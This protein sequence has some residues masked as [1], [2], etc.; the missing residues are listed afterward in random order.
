MTTKDNFSAKLIKKSDTTITRPLYVKS[1][2]STAKTVTVKFPGAESGVYLIALESTDIGRIEETSLE[3]TVEGRVTG[4]V[5]LTG[6]YLGGTLVTITGVNFSNDPLDNP[7]KAGNSWCYVQ[8]TSP[9][10]ITCRVAETGLTAASS[11]PLSTFLRTSEEAVVDI[12]KTFTFATPSATVSS[13]TASFVDSS[14]KQELTLVG[15]GF[16]TDHT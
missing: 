15:I 7:V 14:L 12:D 5:P 2:D 10:Q 6:S 13:L 9:T 11:G 1:V 4:I 16:P 8:T 3:L